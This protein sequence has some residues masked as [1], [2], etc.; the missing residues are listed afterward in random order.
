MRELMTDLIRV[1]GSL[2]PPLNP[3]FL[4][5]ALASDIADAQAELG[6]SFPDDLK[7]LLLSTNGQ[8]LGG[9]GFFYPPEEVD[10]VFPAIRFRPGELGTTSSTW[11]NGAQAIV[12][13]TESA[14][15]WY[16]ELKHDGP[17]ETHGPA[18]YHDQVISFTTTE[19]SDSLVIDLQPAPGGHVGQVVMVR[20]QPFQ[21]AVLAPSLTSFLTLVLEGYKSGRFR[22][23][24]NPPFLD[25]WEDP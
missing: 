25:D 13:T 20:T 17:F 24:A 7:N 21:L 19:N 9:N 2:D 12:S 16:R 23:G 11:L 15:Q 1:F 8:V 4:P 22:F 3:C 5:P 10:P 18:Y 14:R 6:L